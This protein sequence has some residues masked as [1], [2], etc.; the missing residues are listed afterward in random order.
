VSEGIFEVGEP[1]STFAE[2]KHRRTTAR[3]ILTKGREIQ[4]E[5]EI[6]G[7]AINAFSYTLEEE[8]PITTEDT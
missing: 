4:S 3:T 1:P 6:E 2:S 7:G 8:N 5:T